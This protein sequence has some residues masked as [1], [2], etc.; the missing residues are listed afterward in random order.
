MCDWKESTETLYLK[1]D[2]CLP[3]DRTVVI[4]S[5][6]NPQMF[7][8]DEVDIERIERWREAML[9]LLREAYEKGAK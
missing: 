6:N 7:T 9:S 8:V 5:S 4:V 2:V 1:D 3:L